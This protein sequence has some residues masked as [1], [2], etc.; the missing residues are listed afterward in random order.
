MIYDFRDPNYTYVKDNKILSAK[1]E[2][3]YK[4]IC[5][6]CGKDNLIL[7]NKKDLESWKGSTKVV[8]KTVQHVF[9]WLNISQKELLIT[10]THDDCWNKIFKK[11]PR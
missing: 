8:M 4:N 7:I 9:L 6:G 2:I 10:G 11:Q 1:A 3:V 5:I